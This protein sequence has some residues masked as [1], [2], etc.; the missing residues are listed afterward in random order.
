MRNH[1]TITGKRIMDV[2]KKCLAHRR[3]PLWFIICCHFPSWLAI[4]NHAVCAFCSRH[5]ACQQFTVTMRSH[6]AS[7]EQQ[8]VS[9]PHLDVEMSARLAMNIWNWHSHAIIALVFTKSFESIR[10]LFFCL[11]SKKYKPQKP[12]Q[13]LWFCCG[14]RLKSFFDL[15]VTFLSSFV[16]VSFSKCEIVSQRLNESRHFEVFGILTLF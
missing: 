5:D 12:Q 1:R 14:F 7:E 13:R 6:S 4:V 10:N 8:L 9:M 11:P 15:F 2:D 16:C 3:S